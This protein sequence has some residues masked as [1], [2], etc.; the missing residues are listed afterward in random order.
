PAR[1]GAIELVEVSNYPSELM[2]LKLLGLGSILT[3][4]FLSLLTIIVALVMM[5]GRMGNVVSTGMGEMIKKQMEMTRKK[6]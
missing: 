4:I 2:R 6:D 1:V 3:G 5:P